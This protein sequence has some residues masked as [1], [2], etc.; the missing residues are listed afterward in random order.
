MPTW[1]SFHGMNSSVLISL[2]WIFF[3]TWDE[4]SLCQNQHSRRPYSRSRGDLRW[5]GLDTI[6]IISWSLYNIFHLTFSLSLG[7]ISIFCTTSYHTKSASELFI[8][9][10]LSERFPPKSEAWDYLTSSPHLG[11]QESWPHIFW[12]DENLNLY[13]SNF[14][15]G[16]NVVSEMCQR[17][18][19]AAEMKMIFD[20]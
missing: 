3:P 9:S 11:G 5:K 19:K 7:E 16:V 6:L 15:I 1:I 4:S 12:R 14:T 8:S 17:W 10:S 20:T 2:R 18:I 13:S